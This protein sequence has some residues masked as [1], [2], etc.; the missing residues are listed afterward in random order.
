MVKNKNHW[1][2]G[3]F[4]DKLIAPNQDKAFKIAK[5]IITDESG[6]LDVGCGTGRLSFQLSEK[7]KSIDGIDLSERNIRVAK[8]TLRLRFSERISFYHTDAADFLRV[9]RNHYD[10]AVLSYVIH[11]INEPERV[12]LLQLLSEYSNKIILIDYLVPRPGGFTDF[13]N[14]VV[15]FAAGREHFKNFKSY[16]LNNGIHGLAEKSGL[17]IEEEVSGSPETAHIAVLSK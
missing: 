6:I 10:Y 14:G 7:C 1:Y 9:N 5:E 13:V 15:E 4:Y 3:K 12:Q 16:V 8:K 2:D 11:E 17:A